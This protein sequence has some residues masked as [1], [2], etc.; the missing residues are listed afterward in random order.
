MTPMSSRSLVGLGLGILLAACSSAPPHTTS[1]LH[2]HPSAL[3]VD[4]SP[5]D[6]Q[7]HHVVTLA[8]AGDIHFQIQVAA[9]LDDPRG[10]GPIAR[11]LSDADVTMV[12]L[13]SAITDR[14]TWDPKE[15]ERPKDRYWFRAPP[16]ALDVL[17]DAGVDVVTVANNHGADLGAAGLQDTAAG[18]PGRAARGR[19]R[20]P[21]PRR[22]LRA[23]PGPRARDRPRLP[24][25][26]RVAAGEHQQRLD[27]RT[28]YA[29]ARRRPRAT[30]ARRSSAPWRGR[31]AR[32]TWWWS[33]CTGA[34][35][36]RPARPHG[37]APPPVPS[38]R[39]APTS[40]SA[41]TRTCCSAPGGSSDTYVSYGLGNFVWYHDRPPDTGVLRLRLEDG[42]VVA[43]AWTPARI[44]PLG[45]RPCRCRATRGGRRSPTGRCGGAVPGS[46]R[47]D[48]DRRGDVPGDRRED[49]AVPPPTDAQQPARRLPRAL[50][51]AAVPPAGLRRLR[52]PAPHR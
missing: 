1:P 30:A 34:G 5:D 24:G 6:H 50:A 36:C 18:S 25:R 20:G 47:T 32:P 8:F 9:L 4:G 16:R 48:A 21:R 44:G 45:G 39:P 15:L 7:G 49:H 35:T 38:P 12:N 13:E 22:G 28:S 40:S 11:A 3:A 29:G 23:V 42:R 51:R 31:A 14:D 17:A 52:R 27:G 46:P 2:L 41:A 19:R 26:R 37:S 43:D 33:T 10:L